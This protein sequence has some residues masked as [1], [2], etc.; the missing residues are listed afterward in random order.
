M[1]G[2]YRIFR[3]R[4]SGLLDREVIA[5]VC[6][7]YN[8]SLPSLPDAEREVFKEVFIA[9]AYA[10][11]FPFYRPAVVVDIG[12]H[13]GFFTMFAARNLASGARIIAVEP[14]R[15]NTAMLKRH[16]AANGMEELV[17]VVE[18]AVAGHDGTGILHDA[19]SENRSLFASGS[20]PPASGEPVEILSLETLLKRT[21]SIIGRRGIDFL[22][23]DCEGAEYDAL[24][25]APESVLARIRCISL[26]FHDLKQADKTGGELAR[27][28]GSRGFSIVRFAHAT[29]DGN[30]NTGKLLAMRD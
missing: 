26:E 18:A 10:D 15:A 20:Q 3:R 29:T 13:W 1:L 11:G 19:A 16:I 4:V 21:E 5:R 28:L 7:A 27:F 22:K 25:A 8:L 12:A 14:A 6:S 30:L 9:K 17:H 2:A 24:R 23:M